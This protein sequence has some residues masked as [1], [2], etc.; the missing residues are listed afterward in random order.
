MLV[1]STSKQDFISGTVERVTYHNPENGFC[2]LRINVKG[3]KDSVTVVGHINGVFCGEFIQAH[4]L[5]INDKSHGPQ[6]KAERLDSSAPDS[7]EGIQKYLGSGLIKGIG[8]VYAKK[9][10]D[11]FKEDV[12][13]VI[14]NEP[15]RL[16]SVPGIGAKRLSLILKGWKEQ[17]VIREIMVF[18]YQNGVTTA[19]AVRIYKIYGDKSIDLIKENPY[20]LAKDIRGIGF[21]S[22]DKIAQNIGIEKDAS[23]RVRA[24]IQYALL[25]SMSDGHCGIPTQKLISLTKKLLDVD[26]GL[27]VSAIDA[28]L[29]NEEIVTDSI[30]GE[31]CIFLRTLFHIEKS[32]SLHMKRLSKSPLPWSEIDFDKAMRWLFKNNSVQ[33]AESQLSALSKILSSKVCIL[34]GGPGVGKTTLVNSV[35]K[36]L[37]AKQVDI[38]LCAPTGRAAKRL[39]ETT[40][41]EAQTI[42]RLL[43]PNMGEGGFQKKEDNLLSCSL[44]IVDEASMI[45]VSLM[46]SLLKALPSSSG[47]LIV[48]DRDQLPSVG[49]GNVLSDLIS[50]GSLPVVELTEI[51][52]QGSE[53]KIITNAHRINK[54]MY[55][56]NEKPDAGKL[57]DFY[58]IESEENEII[59]EKLIEIVSKRIPNRFS[60]DPVHD[61][62]VLCPMNR[63]SLGAQAL[64][65]SLQTA[66]N[67]NAGH[68]VTRFG[69]TFC[70]GDKVMQ[71]ANDY[72]KEV[73]N[74]DI[75]FVTQIN[76]EKTE[77]TIQFDHRDILYDFGELDNV[78]LAYASTIHKSQGSEFPAVV[79]PLTMSH[80][81]MLKRN[82]FYT[83]VTRGRKLVILIGQ[84]KALNLAIRSTDRDNRW[85]KLREWM[86]LADN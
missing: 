51:F 80:Y 17:K 59:A 53:S 26:E 61:I 60:L 16:K 52:R 12:F 64:N 85:T 39:S 79:I 63:G 11:I 83:G 54:G 13:E 14:E 24:G 50:S 4:G 23:V 47:L 2:V 62:Q 33:L 68:G 57:S 78:T 6:F 35:L 70:I 45:D 19:R 48:G 41:A 77:I 75:G 25:E 86:E 65:I 15:N 71:T 3:K 67:T 7:R 55:I 74:G 18:L 69:W 46:L 84:K 42:H 58:F 72:D 40:G 32:I 66:I 20:R 56:E 28:E 37:K 22:A 31:E 10:V 29:T 44:L 27:I 49:A 5:W 82:L 8:P 36:V 76:E 30:R 1:N 43:Q 38:T 21:V 81:P 9:L 73:F 34:T